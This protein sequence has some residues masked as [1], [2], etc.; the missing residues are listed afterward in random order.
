MFDTH[1]HYDSNAFNDD[2]HDLLASLPN[3]GVSLI[4]N[5]GC[6]VETSQ[7][8]VSYAAQYPH[9]YAAVG[10]HP[11]DCG[12]CTIADLDTIAALAKADKV[13]AIGE[14]GLD[15]YW[16]DNA[17]RDVQEDFF[18]RQ[19]ELAHSLDL[20][21]IVHDREAHGA[22]MDVLGR[23]NDVSGVL[24]C[25]SGSPEMAKWLLDHGYYLGF[26]GPITYK[27]AI[28][29]KEVIAIT[30]LERIVIETDS[31][32]LTPVPFRGKRNDSSKLV[33][34]AE[35]IAQWK[36]ISTEEV[37]AITRDNGKRLFKMEG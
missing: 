33:Y 7:K 5:P 23:Y 29:A 6:D 31:P 11:S 36:R 22:T 34:V 4:V 20:P 30:P 15:F 26:D 27:N 10:I 16:K 2:R 21:I 12:D 1:A 13:V 37:I 24:H 9:V 3:Q 28:K 32:Y 18:C 8:A 35:T 19:I 14:I 17:P 25:F